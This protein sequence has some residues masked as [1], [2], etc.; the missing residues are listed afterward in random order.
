MRLE[1]H[2]Y[3]HPEPAT[4]V[5]LDGI[6]HKVGQIM[7][8]VSEVE[9]KVTAIN[10]KLSKIGNETSGLVQQVADLKNQLADQELPP[11]AQTALDTLEATAQRID[12]MVPD[13][14]PVDGGQPSSG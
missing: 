11:G 3:L 9:G 2:V 12:D 8:K 14:V 10:E 4:S 7:T 1:I 6:N 5:V 13:P